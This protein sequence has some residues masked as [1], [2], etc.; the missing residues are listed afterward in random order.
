MNKKISIIVPVFNVEKYLERCVESLV[1]QT[2]SNIEIILVDD[3]SP[4]NCPQMCDDWAKKDDRIKVVHKEKNEGLGFA[5]NTGIENALG[6]YIIFV[7]SD[8]YIDLKTCETAKNA[9]EKNNA[10]ICCY[11]W[12]DV[13]QNNIKNNHIIEKTVSYEKDRIAQEF[14][15]RSIAPNETDTEKDIGI[16]SCMAIYKASLFEDKKLR[17]VSEREYLN[18]DMIFRIELCK[19]INKAVIIPDNLYFYFHNFG[20]LTTSYKENR[21]AESVKMFE[22]VNEICKDFNCPE[23]YRRNTRYFMLN[24]MV[25]IKKEVAEYGFS[26]IKAIKNICCNETLCNALKQYSI[27]KMPLSYR[28][29]F[30][31]IMSKNAVLI[32]LLVKASLLTNKNKIS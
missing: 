4:D 11:L 12:A 19:H 14:L 16:S 1:N 5:R 13:Y 26:S 8:D 24:T 10:D 20:T 17:F 7:D 9:L 22:K 27:S 32:Y 28:L 31:G 23:L 30:K 18:E 25:S 6:D 2:Y 3:K 29:F 15:T 21:F